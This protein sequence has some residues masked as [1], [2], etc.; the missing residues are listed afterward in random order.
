MENGRFSTVTSPAWEAAAINA[1]MR[2][3]GVSR[4]MGAAQ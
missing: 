2:C 4:A 1:G 3:K